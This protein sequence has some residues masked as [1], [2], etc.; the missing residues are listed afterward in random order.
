MNVEQKDKTKRSKTSLNLSGK[1]LGQYA[2]PN[3]ASMSEQTPFL[4]VTGNYGKIPVQQ[5]IVGS[6]DPMQ[7]SMTRFIA[8][9]FRP[10]KSGLV[11][12]SFEFNAKG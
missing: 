10:E 11:A 7:Q 5:S 12:P 3:Y 1:A 6:V 9:S 4:E 8:G 2:S